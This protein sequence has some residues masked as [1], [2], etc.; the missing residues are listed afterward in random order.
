MEYWHQ[1]S[2]IEIV[3]GGDELELGS[4]EKLEW[5]G[6]SWLAVRI[7]LISQGCDGVTTSALSS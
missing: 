5:V 3:R 6:A 4:G 7:P 2:V 1:C